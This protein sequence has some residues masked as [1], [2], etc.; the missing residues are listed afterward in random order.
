MFIQ[1]QTSFHILLTDVQ[2]NSVAVYI[3]KLLEICIAQ[4]ALK[5]G[6]KNSAVVIHKL[7]MYNYHIKYT[8][9]DDFLKNRVVCRLVVQ[10]VHM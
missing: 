3:H 1:Y 2:N 4:V 7:G 6:G 10:A 8:A 5:S 9:K